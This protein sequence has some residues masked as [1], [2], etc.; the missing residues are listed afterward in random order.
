MFAKKNVFLYLAFICFSL[1]SCSQAPSSQT[2]LQFLPG[3]AQSAPTIITYNTSN[4]KM[5]QHY[6]REGQ[7]TKYD[8][9]PSPKVSIKGPLNVKYLP[10][11][12]GELPS[13]FASNNKG[14]FEFFYLQDGVWKKND[15]L[16]AGKASLN[17]KDVHVE[18]TPS[19]AGNLAFI[20]AF[21]ADGKEF[22]FY[23]I[24]DGAWVKNTSIDQTL[25]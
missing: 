13:L 9:F 4:G 10:G 17:S 1:S 8:A 22:S 11:G 7:W 18:F 14:A 23:E 25:D 15:L 5:V 6:L 21:S 19:I 16:P 12:P 24:K 20:S 3:T 2:K